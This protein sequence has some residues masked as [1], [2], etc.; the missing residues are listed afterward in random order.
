MSSCRRIFAIN[1]RCRP[2]LLVCTF[3]HWTLVFARSKQLPLGEAGSAKPRL[4]RAEEHLHIALQSQQNQ[5]GSPALIRLLRFAP[6]PPSPRG[7]H[8]PAAN[9]YSAANFEHRTF[10]RRY[11]NVTAPKPDTPISGGA[12][13]DA[14]KVTPVWNARRKHWFLPEFRGS[15]HPVT[16]RTLFSPIFSLARE[17]MGPPEARQK[18]PRRNESLQAR[19]LILCA[20]FSFPNRKLNLRFGFFYANL[21]QPLSQPSADSSPGRGSLRKRTPAGSFL[22][23]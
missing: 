18:R 22:R 23:G 5:N 14:R 21:L 16:P 7:R 17:K 2:D 11:S 20:R 13:P 4:M 15:M 10:Y 3:L 6:Q 8:K 19:L 12:Y 9:P 1:R